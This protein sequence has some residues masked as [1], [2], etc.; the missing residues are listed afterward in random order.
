ML[1]KSHNLLAQLVVAGFATEVRESRGDIRGFNFAAG[2]SGC[3][4]LTGGREPQRLRIQFEQ[5]WRLRSRVTELEAQL[6]RM[7]LRR[8][9]GEQQVAVTHGI[10]SAGTA[11]GAADLITADGFV[12]VMHHDQGG[13]RS[14]AQTQQAL[15]Q[16]GH[17]AGIVFVL[18]VGGAQRVQDGNL[19]G[20]G[21]G[22]SE[23][24]IQALRRTEEM[25]GGVR[26]HEDIL[27]GGAS[28]TVAALRAAARRSAVMA[29]L[30]T[31]RGMP[32]VV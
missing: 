22:G 29:S 15:A 32:L 26:I 23:E 1:P 7:E 3:R 19:G 13:A 18:I 25:A 6:N 9:S 12:H 30:F 31:L 20:G 28:F 17:G 16:S 11:E 8:R 24:V 21:T 10:Q 27:I 4:R 14:F 2:R 5:A